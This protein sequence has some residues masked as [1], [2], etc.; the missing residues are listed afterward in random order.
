[1]SFLGWLFFGLIAGFVASK[2]VK[3]RGSGCIV[4][5]A[6][7]ILG[8]VVGG[9]MFSF[10]GHPVWFRFSLQSMIVAILGA[11]VV[12]VVFHAIIGRE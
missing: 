2:A 11:V 10:L 8:A 3:G 6:L 7:G 9:A 5:I 4:N 12:L 1:M